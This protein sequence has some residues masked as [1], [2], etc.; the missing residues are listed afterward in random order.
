MS[1]EQLTRQAIQTRRLD[2]NAWSWIRGYIDRAPYLTA[3]EYDALRSL[4]RALR[5]GQVVSGPSS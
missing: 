5:A 4:G 3:N 1:L 2:E